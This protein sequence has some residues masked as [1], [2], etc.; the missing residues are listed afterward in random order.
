MKHVSCNSDNQVLIFENSKIGSENVSLRRTNKRTNL[1]VR[2][3][4][5]YNYEYPCN[6]HITKEAAHWGKHTESGDDIICSL[7]TFMQ[8]YIHDLIL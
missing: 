5:L 2:K 4:G 8:K 3:H 7:Y 6:I 1:M